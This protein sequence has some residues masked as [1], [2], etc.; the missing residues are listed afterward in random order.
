MKKAI[1]IAYNEHFDSECQS[2]SLAGF[3]YIAVNYTSVIGKNAD[4]WKNITEDILVTLDKYS[5]ECVQSHPHYYNPF[6]SSEIV[7]EEMEFAMRQ[8]IISSAQIGAE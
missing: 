8:S 3:S 6:E 1:Q 7:D 4:E 2:V 5:L